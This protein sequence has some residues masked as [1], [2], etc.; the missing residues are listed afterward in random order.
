MKLQAFGKRLLYAIIPSMKK[1]EMKAIFVRNMDYLFC[2]VLVVLFTAFGFFGIFKK[3][4][5]R[6]YDI[7]LSLRKPPVQSE[8]IFH[9]NIDNES[10]D[11]LGEW[12]WSRD[13]YADLLI[14]M[15][16][17]GAERAVFD[18]EYLSPSKKG[19]PSDAIPNITYAFDVQ[20]NDIAE[21]VYLL[22]ERFSSGHISPSEI[23]KV[24]DEL[25][26]DVINPSMSQL[27]DSVMQ[28]AY[29][30]NDEYFSKA[31]QFFGNTWLTVN[32]R[33]VIFS[34]TEEDIKYIDERLLLKNVS[35]SK[36]LITKDNHFTSV[37]QYM[38]EAAGFS[39]A[40][41]TFLTRA[42]G[43]GFTNVVVDSDGVRRRVELLFDHNGK[44]L[45][46][47]TFAPLLDFLDVRQVE[48]KGRTLILRNAK[49]PFSDAREDVRIPLDEHG[50]MLINWLHKDF[51]NS[52]KHESVYSFLQLKFL[53]D[54]IN[55]NLNNIASLSLLNADGSPLEYLG[56]AENLILTGNRIADEKNYM[57]SL[58]TGFD[59]EN[60]PLDGIS[61]EVY[62]KYF[63]LKNDFYA[64]VK[65]YA[66]T[67]FF[68]E[69]DMRLEELRP[70]AGKETIDE[71][72]ASLKNEF[73]VLKDNVDSYISSSTELGKRLNESICIIGNTASSTTDIGATPFDRTYYNV[74]THA[75][76]LNTVLQKNFI[77]PVSWHYG[78]LA[79]IFISIA[80][81][82][83]F[84]S[85]THAA[86]NIANGSVLFIALVVPVFLMVFAGLYI[87]FSVYLFF[88]L[89]NFVSGMALRFIL[90]AK[91]KHFI[92]QIAASFAN[93]DTV[94]SLRK[95][96]EA[97]KTDGQKKN[98]SALFSDIQKFSTFSENMGLIYGSEGPNKLIENLN[99]YLGAMSNEILKNNGTIDKYEGDA[100]ISMF[101]APDPMKTHNADQWAFLCLASAVNMKKV[102]KEFNESHK[103]LFRKYIVNVRG[104]NGEN[105]E[106][107]IELKPFQTRIGINS[108]EAFVG[109]MGSK[110]E[111]FSKLNYTMIGDTVN[112]AARLEGVNKA[113]GTWI[114]CSEDT[115][116]SANKG[117]NEG[118]LVAKRLDRVRVVGRATPVQLY[119][120]IGFRNEM[121]SALLLGIEKFREALELYL[122][123]DFLNARK[124]F[125]EAGKINPEDGASAVFAERCRLYAEKGVEE[126]WNGVMN[127]TSK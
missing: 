17:L 60:R 29:R 13:I 105:S 101:G 11:A 55:Q 117:E 118:K 51:G 6:F 79:A 3:L 38:G 102:E 106:K 123:R 72:K 100:I 73:D 49:Y 121:D 69:I 107:E 114:M 42:R 112:L 39:P 30:D 35:D 67:D 31:I 87:P 22:G 63:G 71:F 120:V 18:I 94:D 93:K 89:S 26:N 70:V 36:K 46:Q 37:D 32:T 81:M 124:L 12:P 7:L 103:E 122:A 1:K 74:G 78:F 92:T 24:T 115:W 43:V 82:F 61:Y 40:L 91:E 85:G 113:Y 44:H 16:E 57:L 15:K 88:V 41:H 47:L 125:V 95:N 48:R 56:E 110:T 52:F 66:S 108:G 2:S 90:S 45:G 96:P 65:K 4:D 80:V 23:R 8:R 75:N 84:H 19:V 28:N 68:K 86:Q 127:M 98:I 10:I 5:Y 14:Q 111:S 99:A 104:E 34:Q 64:S 76:V 83:A 33:E 119:N 27:Y 116:L 77:R 21:S 109:L 9:V 59:I 53:E 126:S 50:R 97:F 20:G 54:D 58:C 25:V 62:G